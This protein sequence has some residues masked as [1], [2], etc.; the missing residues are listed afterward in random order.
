MRLS[1]GH[2]SNRR[3]AHTDTPPPVRHHPSLYL[4]P[5]LQFD[6]PYCHPGA[7]EQHIPP[8]ERVHAFRLLSLYLPLSESG[9]LPGLNFFR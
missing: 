2:V 9:W 4:A 7:L 1:L 5:I 8:P 6:P 3:H